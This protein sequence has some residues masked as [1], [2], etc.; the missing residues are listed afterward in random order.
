[1]ATTVSRED[2]KRILVSAYLA[3]AIGLAWYAFIHPYYNWDLIPYVAVVLS[4]DESDPRVVH[5]R[6]YEEVRRSV[7]DQAYA[8][9]TGGPYR[10]EMEANV[11]FFT[12]QLPFYKIRPLYTGLILLGHRAGIPVV[13]AA[14]C[15][16][17]LP[18]LLICAVILVWMLRYFDAAWASALSVL[19][20]GASGVTEA[21]RIA[22]PDAL[23]SALLIGSALLFTGGKHARPAAA[24]LVLS[25]LARTDNILPALLLLG[26]FRFFGENGGAMRWLDHLVSSVLC[27]VAYLG[28]AGLAGGYSWAVV[29]HHTFLRRLGNPAEFHSGIGVAEYLRVVGRALI[30]GIMEDRS[31][32]FFSL[33]ALITVMLAPRAG[34]RAAGH[35]GLAILMMLGVAAHFVLFPS[36]NVRFF[37]ANYAVICACL[38]GTVRAVTSPGYDAGNSSAA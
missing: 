24:L 17:V 31:F 20:A 21:S 10:R 38:L 19:V 8:E 11:P 18:G 25:V 34:R 3:I 23:S 30:E 14:L 26:Y 2:M 37:V 7:P 1:M 5:Q 28:T 13:K 6:A 29:F 4:Y 33:C 22:T 16:S 12:Q 32:Y 36:L 15:A 9:L 27:I 35:R